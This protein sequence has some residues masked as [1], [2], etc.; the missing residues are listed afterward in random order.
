MG[1][2]LVNIQL[3][4]N[5]R[6][7]LKRYSAKVGIPMSGLLRRAIREYLVK[8]KNVRLKCA[9]LVRINMQFIMQKICV[10]IV[11]ILKEEAKSRGIVHMLINHIMLWGYVKIVIK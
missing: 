11:I 8:R 9:R 1:K 6:E 3:E 7:L 10:Q 2:V 4:E 5:E